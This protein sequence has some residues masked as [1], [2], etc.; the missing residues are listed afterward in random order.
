MFGL[1]RRFSFQFNIIFCVEQKQSFLLPSN[2]NL[3]VSRKP[4]IVGV[5]ES[6]VIELKERVMCYV[7]KWFRY[8]YGY[9]D[10]IPYHFQ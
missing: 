7:K 6:R 8:Y 4:Q 9:Y 1:F 2:I 10:I 5:L 3:G